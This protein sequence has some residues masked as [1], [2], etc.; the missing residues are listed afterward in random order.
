MML[1]IMI[2]ITWRGYAIIITGYTWTCASTRTQTPSLRAPVRDGSPSASLRRRPL[3]TCCEWCRG[4]L[5]C[6]VER[7][8]ADNDGRARDPCR[9]E[10]AGLFER[11]GV[12][13]LRWPLPSLPSQQPTASFQ[14][15]D[16]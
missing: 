13:E 4:S 15:S 11:I 3:R 2:L 14:K 16:N 10:R 1:R 12:D 6:T 9:D 8:G 5:A 7:D